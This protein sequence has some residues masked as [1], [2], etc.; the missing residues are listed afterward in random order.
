MQCQPGDAA[1]FCPCSVNLLMTPVSAH[2]VYAP[3]HLHSTYLYPNACI[4]CLPRCSTSCFIPLDDSCRPQCLTMHQQYL[5]TAGVQS[6]LLDL[7]TEQHS[8]CSAC[9]YM[10]VRYKLKCLTLRQQYLPTAGV[11]L[12]SAGTS[13]TATHSIQ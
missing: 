6:S 9:S 2:A 13:G 10:Q 1:C 4:P 8:Q 12:F 7:T 11:Q 3:Q 5:P